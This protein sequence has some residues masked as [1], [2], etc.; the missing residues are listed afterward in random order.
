MEE[1]KRNLFLTASMNEFAINGYKKASTDKIVKEANLSKGLLFYYF[2]TKKDLYLFLFEYSMEI[3]LKDYYS[4]VDILERDIL[5]RLKKLLLL[6]MELTKK[7]PNIF[8]FVASAFYEKDP[9]VASK[10]SMDNKEIFIQAEKKL[11]NNI[12]LSLFKPEI[13][14]KLAIDIILFTF[15]GYSNLQGEAGK[16]LEDYNKEYPRYIKEID[17]YIKTLKIAFYRE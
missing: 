4:H 6:K 9:S 8:E 13:N 1:Y 11:I 7:Y 10:I 17:E 12:N 5:K 14:P 15:K 2:G 16:K 3:I